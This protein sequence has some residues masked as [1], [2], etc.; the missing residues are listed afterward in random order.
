MKIKTK[1]AASVSAIALCSSLTTGVANAQEMGSVE[2]T[3]QGSMAVGSSALPVLI[4][5]ALV[6]GAFALAMNDQAP[7]P[8]V[9][10]PGD[11]CAPH[12]IG[13]F[14]VNGLRCTFMGGGAPV[15]WVAVAGDIG[16]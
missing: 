1:V 13:Q 4:P 6:G 5:L 2:Q 3:A 11:Y 16:G 10:S 7:A 8:W 14:S 9:P 15:R 12:Q